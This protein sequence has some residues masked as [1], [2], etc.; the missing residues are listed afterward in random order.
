MKMI[1][2]NGE[3]VAFNIEK[4]FVAVAKANKEV[5]L[6]EQLSE[7][8]IHSISERVEEYCRDSQM[9]MNVEAIQDVVENE[10]MKVGAFS[11]AK[12]YITY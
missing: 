3:E 4:I 5:P 6:A 8:E 12:K 7:D 2:R 10:I 1:K 9:Q 11:I